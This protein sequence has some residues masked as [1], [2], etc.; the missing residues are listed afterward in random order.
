MET[1]DMEG[2]YTATALPW[3]LK[4][5]SVGLFAWETNPQLEQRLLR[6]AQ[7]LLT[8][9][10]GQSLHY[11][12]HLRNGNTDSQL[13][14]KPEMSMSETWLACQNMIDPRPERSRAC[15][16]LLQGNNLPLSLAFP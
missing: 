2:L 3:L 1:K 6:D 7:F 8:A 13:I 9:P 10:A 11:C 4:G 16:E 14:P 5:A 12:R 15:D